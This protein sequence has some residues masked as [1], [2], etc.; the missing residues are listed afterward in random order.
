VQERRDSHDEA[1]NNA[2]EVGLNQVQPSHQASSNSLKFSLKG[3]ARDFSIKE[4]QKIHIN[5]PVVK[6]FTFR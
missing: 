1:E 6:C 5:V 4:G 2:A 3:A